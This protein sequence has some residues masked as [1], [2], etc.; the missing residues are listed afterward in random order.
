MW[1]LWNLRWFSEPLAFPNSESPR[2]P[3]Q[4]TSGVGEPKITRG[5]RWKPSGRLGL[6]FLHH[7][8]QPSPPPKKKIGYQPLEVLNS[9]PQSKM[10]KSKSSKI[11]CPS[12][13]HLQLIFFG[14]KMGPWEA[15]SLRCSSW[16]GESFLRGKHRLVQYMDPG[17]KVEVL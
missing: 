5:K 15:W 2:L 10:E 13:S 14:W 17:L 8:L 3:E 12:T 6:L 7:T 4:N 11:L 9:T 16:K 1:K